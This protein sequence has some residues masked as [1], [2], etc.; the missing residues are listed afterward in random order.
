M[1]KYPKY[2]QY[3]ILTL[4]LSERLFSIIFSA[5][6]HASAA[7]GT[8]YET[9]TTEHGIKLATKLRENMLVNLSANL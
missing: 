4:K 3:F 1:T 7:R 8:L 5:F 9:I 2:T 6:G